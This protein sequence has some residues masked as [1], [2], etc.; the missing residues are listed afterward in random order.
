MSDYVTTEEARKILGLDSRK[1]VALALR[2]DRLHGRKFG[3]VWMVSRASLR[4]YRVSRPNQRNGRRLT[5]SRPA[6]AYRR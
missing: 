3:R 2:E 4:R 6:V 1:T 5:S